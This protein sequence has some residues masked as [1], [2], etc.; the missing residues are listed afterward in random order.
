MCAVI[1]SERRTLFAELLRREVTQVYGPPTVVAAVG[2]V[3]IVA[4]VGIVSSRQ[5]LLLSRVMLHDGILPSRNSPGPTA[6]APLS[7]AVERLRVCPELR[8]R[9]SRLPA[10]RSG[11]QSIA[12]SS[13]AA[14]G[15][16]T[17]AGIEARSM[18]NLK[19]TGSAIRRNVL[20]VGRLK[21]I[22]SCTQSGE[23]R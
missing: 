4:R 22:D 23:S 17:V 18:S 20:G 10:H 5:R 9:F 14:M 15:S 12:W 19:S 6:G 16:A 13:G 1:L 7:N 21:T 8:I 11:P 2:T 3:A